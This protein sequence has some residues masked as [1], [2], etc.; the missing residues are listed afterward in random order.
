MSSHEQEAK[1]GTRHTEEQRKEKGERGESYMVTA[2]GHA[3]WQKLHA[4]PNLRHMSEALHGCGS[5]KK[6]DFWRW[7]LLVLF[8]VNYK[9]AF[10][11]IIKYYITA[12]DTLAC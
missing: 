2:L 1:T 4:L 6:T 8:A 10:K 11:Y 9:I 12:L 7:V 3:G 5:A